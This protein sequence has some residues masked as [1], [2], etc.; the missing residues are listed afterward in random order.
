MNNL[1]LYPMRW[2]LRIWLIALLLAPLAEA[3]AQWSTPL[4]LPKDTRS[5]ARIS[6]PTKLVGYVSTGYDTGSTYK[7]TDGGKSWTT[8]VMPRISGTVR[9]VSPDTGYFY[10]EHYFARSANGGANWTTLVDSLPIRVSEL[11]TGFSQRG[12]LFIGGSKPN[13]KG[14]M[15]L[16]TTDG[17]ATWTVQHDFDRDYTVTA[18]SFVDSLCGIFSTYESGSCTVFVNSYY[19]SDGGVTVTKPYFVY[20]PFLLLSNLEGLGATYNGFARTE[21]AWLTLERKLPFSPYTISRG[22]TNSLFAISG[23]SLCFS[24]DRGK[25][26]QKLPVPSEYSAS[27]IELPDD[28]TAIVLARDTSKGYC[29]LRFDAALPDVKP[30]DSSDSQ[31][32][33]QK[34]RQG[35]DIIA[36]RGLQEGFTQR[37]VDTLRVAVERC[38]TAVD[39]TT[40]FPKITESLRTLSSNYPD[41]IRWRRQREWLWSVLYL[42]TVDKYYCAA[43]AEFLPTFEPIDTG[44]GFDYNGYV[45]VIDYLLRS[46]RCPSYASMLGSARESIRK[47]QRSLYWDTVVSPG[48][49]PIDTAALTIDAIG[50]ARLRDASAGIHS[51]RETVRLRAVTATRD[52]DRIFITFT[53]EETAN[54][55][56]SLCDILGRQSGETVRVRCHSGPNSFELPLRAIPKGNYFLR[57]QTELGEVRSVR[58]SLGN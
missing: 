57:L 18:L 39:V 46:G 51:G 20:P 35:F 2:L 40:A 34:L 9:F 54:V 42:S 27:A 38:A 24:V 11:Q 37:G 44:P 26:W 52:G 14:A 25:S 50:F 30:V 5:P 41:S 55:S 58:V 6:F 48:Q 17:G 28:S 33:A 21:D 13:H 29:L 43:A 32:C 49:S 8:L 7:T 10:S 16:R 45:A 3:S 22:P 23:D 12:L 19:T 15:L 53:L 47:K 31:R 56:V 1:L 36:Q 4:P